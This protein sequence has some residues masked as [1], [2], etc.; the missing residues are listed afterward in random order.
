[1]ITHKII[2][3]QFGIILLSLCTVF[4]CTLFLNINIDMRAIKDLILT[5][6]GVQIYN[7]K[8]IMYNTIIAACGGV[9]GLIIVLVLFFTIVN[10]IDDNSKNLGILKALGYSRKKLALMF[11]KYGLCILFGSIIGFIIAFCFMPV[12]YNG[13]NDPALPNVNIHFNFLTLLFTVII[14]YM[15]FT[16]IGIVIAFWKLKKTPLELIKN[17]KKE[18]KQ[19]YKERKN[20]EYASFIIEVKYNS[21]KRSKMPLLFTLIG[22]FCFSAQIQMSLSMDSLNVSVLFT[23]II[24]IVGILLG[25]TTLIISLSSVVKNNKDY[26]AILK[27]YGYT[28]KECNIMLFPLYR[29]TSY[30]GFIIGT[31]YQYF[32]LKAM[33]GLFTGPYDMVI[34]YRFNFKAF[35]ITIFSFI[36]LFEFLMYLYK[37]QIKKLSLK[38]VIEA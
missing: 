27:A 23:G 7:A 10:Y 29:I 19:T 24:L 15:I 32:F 13:F 3:K 6:E 20:K 18:K 34:E 21:I 25:T 4:V 26:L 28:N 9:V 14:P 5:T 37:T 11:Y 22:A 36:I 8:M 12:V 35:V 16:I 31:H 17:I 33:V 30:L 2:F 1:M 38:K